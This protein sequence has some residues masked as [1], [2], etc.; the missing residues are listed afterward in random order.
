MF[1]EVLSG[2]FLVKL[3]EYIY[4]EYRRKS[5]MSKSAKEVVNKHLDPILKAADELVGK[6]R[7]LAQ[8]DFKELLYTAKQED[9]KLENS[10]PLLEVLFL[11]AQFWSRIQILRMESIYINLSSDKTGK[12][13]LE[14]FWAL[15][16]TKTRLVDRAWQRGMG[17]ALICYEGTIRSI[18]Y[19]EFVKKYLISEEYRAWFQP[20]TALLKELSQVKRRQRLLLYGIIVNALI[21]TLDK[22]HAITRNRPGWANKL[23]QKNKREIKHRVFPVYLKFVTTPERYYE[24]E[25]KR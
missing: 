4:G 19:F 24:I 23:N 16:A 7:S 15:E 20:L 10:M 3:S 8:S 14:F 13:M 25:N 17:E 1:F 21:D 5:D 6:I 22:T 11:F 2:G 9:L 12:Q 18:S